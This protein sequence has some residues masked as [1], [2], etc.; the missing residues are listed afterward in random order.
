M[1]LILSAALLLA[2]HGQRRQAKAFEVA[3]AAIEQA[4]EAAVAA[5]EVTRDLGGRL[6]TRAA[7]TALAARIGEM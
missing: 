7:G 6:G 5:G 2:W 4:A 1:S 3:A